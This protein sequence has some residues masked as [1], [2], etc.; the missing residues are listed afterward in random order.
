MSTSNSI[1]IDKLQHNLPSLRKVAGWTAEDL[2]QKLGV[3]K[4]TISN[5]ETG[6]TAMTKLHYIAL[7]AILDYE[8]RS[9][10]NLARSL[11]LVLDDREAT[12]EEHKAHEDIVK[13]VAA[14]TS[15]GVTNKAL[16]VLL[17]AA[18]ITLGA[19]LA[20]VMNNDK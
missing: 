6:R 5:I 2:A 18:T 3:T 16:S 12:E 14:A 11:L 8:A 19:W 9:N 13:A 10:P 1:E 17:G 15:A 20:T 7:R 4:Q